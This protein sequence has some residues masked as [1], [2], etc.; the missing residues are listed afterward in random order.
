LG[1]RKKIM[2]GCAGLIVVVVAFLTFEPNFSTSP[3]NPPVVADTAAVYTFEQQQDALRLWI[4]DFELKTNAVNEQWERVSKIAEDTEYRGIEGDF[5]VVQKN[6]QNLEGIYTALQPP[7]ELTIEQQKILEQ[8]SRNMDDSIVSRIKYIK[9]TKAYNLN[10]RH[11][12][13]RRGQEQKELID[14]Y[15]SSSSKEIKKL[16]EIYKLQ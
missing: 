10:Q 13:Y 2:I 9:Y 14:L 4:K 16:A 12:N 7:K 6:L 5:E 11:V 8:I 15:H 1:L 3:A